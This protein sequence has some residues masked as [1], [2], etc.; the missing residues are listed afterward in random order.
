MTKG[1]RVEEIVNVMAAT[2]PNVFDSVRALANMGDDLELLRDASAA[3]LDEYPSW[4]SDIEAK[5][6]ATNATGVQHAAHKLRG[7]L[8]A[9]CADEASER[10]AELERLGKKGDLRFAE[11][12]F[13]EMSGAVDRFARQL[14]AFVGL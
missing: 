11:G 2:S 8:L 6:R 10:A 9:L 13:R 12:V 1:K 3:F 4:V 7:A 14:G 5:L